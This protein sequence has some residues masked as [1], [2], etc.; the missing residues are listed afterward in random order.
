MV[1]K[2]VDP[3]KH[4]DWLRPHSAK[5]YQQVRR[6]H[7]KYEYSWNSIVEEPNGE[8][9]FDQEILKMVK[10]KKA[11]D[12]GCG[13]G[14]IAITCSPVAKEIVGFDF[15]KQF[16]GNGKEQKIENLSF[17]LGSIK[18]GLPFGRDEFDCA[19]IRK[20]PTSSYP[21]LSNVV[22][23]GG[24]V[25]GL[26]PGDESGNELLYL[27]PNMYKGLAITLSHYM[28]RAVL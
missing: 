18:E 19:Y 16:I 8:S 28:V 4:P 12:V 7:G 9:L 10:D 21:L 20:G 2:L 11:L 14:D 24:E 25:L 22:K 1:V 3:S 26:H 23:N 27:F 15:T 6:H 13:H 17:V 5:W